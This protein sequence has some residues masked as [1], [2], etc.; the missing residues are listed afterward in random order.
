M[1]EAEDIALGRFMPPYCVYRD[2]LDSDTHADL[3]AWA[4]GNEAKF[5]PTLVY[6]AKHNPS[7]RKSLGVSDFG[8]LMAI[9]RQR[10]LDLVPALVR[11]LRVTPFE[12]SEVELEMVA[13]N[14]G[15]F[16]ARHI[17]TFTGETREASDRLLSVVYYFHAEP[18]AF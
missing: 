14:D 5:E 11:D 7:E 6:G 16:F 12:P 3:L 9:F 4:I 10:I 15:A 18:K 13:N 2:F 17:D 1:T 8:P